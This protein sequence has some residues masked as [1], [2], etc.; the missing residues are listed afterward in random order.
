MDKG[1]AS[2]ILQRAEKGIETNIAYS[3][4]ATVIGRQVVTSRTIGAGAKANSTLI[5]PYNGIFQVDGA[6]VGDSTI[7]PGS[8]GVDGIV[9][10]GDIEES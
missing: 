5:R 10:N 4:Q 7:A 2:V 9:V 8:I 1:G 6:A 3:C